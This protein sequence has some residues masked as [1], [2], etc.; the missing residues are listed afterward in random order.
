MSIVIKNKLGPIDTKL[1]GIR[2][3][4]EK[5]R[6]AVDEQNM[7]LEKLTNS[8]AQLSDKLNTMQSFI[9]KI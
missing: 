3:D 1:S 5:L 6:A 8:K 2:D 4:L 9:L 7:I